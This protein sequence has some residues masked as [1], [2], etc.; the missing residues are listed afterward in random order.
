MVGLAAQPELEQQSSIVKC[1]LYYSLDVVLNGEAA[2]GWGGLAQM[3]LQVSNISAL[4][5]ASGAAAASSF[6]ASST[7][8]ADFASLR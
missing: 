4:L 7:I 8:E 1:H 6:G 5:I 2:K 3:G